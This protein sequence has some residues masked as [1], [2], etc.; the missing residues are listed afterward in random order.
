M[1]EEAANETISLMEE[2]QGPPLVSAPLMPYPPTGPQQKKHKKPKGS[3]KPRV[4]ILHAKG[5]DQTYEVAADANLLIFYQII[6][7][8]FSRDQP[9]PTSEVQSDVSL[10]AH[11][12]SC[13]YKCWKFWTGGVF[14]MKLVY[15]DTAK[16]EFRVLH[17]TPKLGVFTQ[18][19]TE[20]VFS[21]REWYHVEI[22]LSEESLEALA[23]FIR[24]QTNAVFNPFYHRLACWGLC[25]CACCH[26]EGVDTDAIAPERNLFHPS[27]FK[28][29]RYEER[30]AAWGPAQLVAAC[31]VHCG[32]I[33]HQVIDVNW[34]TFKQLRDQMRI[35]INQLK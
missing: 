24:I 1:S 22:T 14:D 12:D 29:R 31:L 20:W 4:R 16:Q 11:A 27:G 8:Q 30:M 6:P 34:T 23:R 26:D 32:L 15:W 17:N 21:P 35:T 7:P 9:P 33:N 13:A 25:C 10:L 3:P 2:A 18:P 28:V 19:F 5:K